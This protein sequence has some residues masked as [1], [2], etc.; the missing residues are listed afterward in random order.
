[1]SKMNKIDPSYI[2]NIR[3]G[4]KIENIEA[5]NIEALPEGLVGLYDKELF[6]PSLKWK[7]R[8]ETLQFFLVFA[9]A[10]KEI[11]VDFVSTILG[12]EWCKVLPN[13]NETSEEKRLKKVNEFIQLHSK[14]FT[15]AGEGKYR[16][17]HERFRLYILQ[18]VSESDLTQFNQKFISLCESELKKNTE[19]DIPE[20][21]YY[22]LEFLSTHYFISAMQGEKLCLNKKDAA[23]LKNLAYDQA[24]WERQVKASKGF[25]W[26]KKMLNEIMSWASKFD[27]EEVIECALNKVDL[28]HQEQNDAPR[29]VQL[30]A[31]G[32]IE[33]ALERIEKFGGEDKEGLQ[34]K[35]ILYMLCLMEL[36]LLDSKDKEHSKSSI[37]KILKHFDDKLPIE[38][39]VLNWNDFF[40]SYL[41]FLMAKEWAKSNLDFLIIYKRSLNWNYTWLNL[42]GPYSDLDFEILQKIAYIIHDKED[43]NN[44]CVA[45]YLQMY[46]QNKS[47]FLDLLLNNKEFDLM[48]D[49]YLELLKELDNEKSTFVYNLCCNALLEIQNNDLKNVKA[50][51]LSQ[52]LLDFDLFDESINVALI[53]KGKIR[54]K[55]LLN[56]AIKGIELDQTELAI[57]CSEKMKDEETKPAN[58]LEISKKLFL[59]N[60]GS[61]Y[62]ILNQSLIA[63]NRLTKAERKKQL[64]EIVLEMLKHNLTEAL[65]I[66]ESL[67]IKQD[68]IPEKVFGEIAV[69]YAEIGEFEK[70]FEFLKYVKYKREYI[71][72]VAVECANHNLFENAIDLFKSSEWEGDLS[73]KIK[74]L[75]EIFNIYW[76][77]G[78]KNESQKVKILAEGLINKT[79]DILEKNDLYKDLLLA[80]NNQHEFKSA[81][82]IAKKIKKSSIKVEVFLEIARELWIQNNHQ[83]SKILIDEA[84]SEFVLIDIGNSSKDKFLKLIIDEMINQNRENDII[85]IINNNLISSSSLTITH[86]VKK[87]LEVNDLKRA[88]DIIK[89][90]NQKEAILVNLE[91]SEYLFECGKYAESLKVLSDIQNSKEFNQH[92]NYNLK[93]SVSKILRKHGQIQIS[94][95]LLREALKFELKIKNSRPNSVFKP[96]YDI[97][98][99]F[100][101]QGL[102][103]E[104]IEIVNQIAI[105]NKSNKQCNTEK[106]YD[107]IIHSCLERSEFERALMLLIKINSNE[108]S[109]KEKY[110][111]AILSKSIENDR[112]SF[113]KKVLL[114]VV[115]STRIN[116]QTEKDE[117]L[118]TISKKF[119]DLTKID[120]SIK[121]V[122]EIKN[123]GLKKDLINELFIESDDEQAFTLEKLIKRFGSSNSML[124]MANLY[125]KNNNFENAISILNYVSNEESKLPIYYAIFSNI[126]QLNSIIESEVEIKKCL[127]KIHHRNYSLKCKN[128][129]F[130]S[131]ELYKIGQKNSSMNYLNEAIEL[132]SKINNDEFNNSK[133]QILISTE[134]FNQNE[135]DSSQKLLSAI[136]ESINL[137]ELPDD[138]IEICSAIY[139]ERL[140]QGEN[141]KVVIE[142]INKISDKD[143]QNSIFKNISRIL[144]LEEKWK[145]AFE[146]TI[147]L[148]WKWD[149]IQL[150]FSEMIKR[151]NF[152]LTLDLANSIDN[153]YDRCL[154]YISISKEIFK[155]EQKEK[156][157]DLLKEAIVLIEKSKDIK[158]DKDKNS[159]I[160]ELSEALAHVELFEL[161]LELLDNSDIYYQYLT[162]NIYI[163]WVKFNSD[164]QNTMILIEKHLK[165]L[166]DEDRKKYIKEICLY[167]VEID[168]IDFVNDILNKLISELDFAEDLL[169]V[170]S[171]ELAKKNNSLSIDLALKII[172]NDLLV[173]TLEKLSDSFIDNENFSLCEYVTTKIPSKSISTK[174]LKNLGEKLFETEGYFKAMENLTEFTNPESIIFIRKGIVEAISMDTIS[175]DIVKDVLRN[176]KIEE[177]YKEKIIKYSAINQLFFSN[178]PKEKLDRYNRTLNLQWAIDIKN[179]LPN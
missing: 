150:L 175:K 58:L 124:K 71:P 159:L 27:E 59:K 51:R 65:N 169:S 6:P 20:K 165:S 40:P 83:D 99:E 95:S 68:K 164:S 160:R 162:K 112:F 96:L 9:L 132:V 157:Q 15:S 54:D 166:Y 29:I 11:S 86:I 115:S 87:I 109:L 70:A 41:M 146:L 178:L 45:I 19:K 92:Y 100:V 18:K 173:K 129:V 120:Y 167:F 117:K 170:I 144:I 128:L 35:F 106:L 97:A 85:N 37:E 44:T 36:T 121:I 148:E 69:R 151:T 67:D 102:F 72:K 114:E 123:K 168:E 32:D 47:E 76:E 172:N 179:Q 5:N 80:L 141:L 39:S 55:L 153:S 113:N 156:A 105:E 17:Y 42:K 66:L 143:F 63:S 137:I 139:F 3:D 56:I 84:I 34:R 147:L 140:R 133:I 134:L 30:V 90:I 174:I 98:Q 177:V 125:L 22:A 111:N 46:I 122:N 50:S 25:E 13:E 21:E 82:E 127:D 14:R 119:K 118:Y 94:N 78:R 57:K 110:T 101:N 81:I 103:E 73:S 116:S 138:K 75:I 48:L 126:I 136:L 10:Q 61:S 107:L 89:N 158:L 93:L 33:T 8:K 88:Y 53:A 145:D 43:R 176:R 2:R 108:I 1:M 64:V 23:L 149:E 131:K 171:I 26:S 12:D 7:E 142:R 24:Y 49:L 130:I 62:L 91:I 77:S 16:L 154:A 104:V 135:I 163:K 79:D 31:D 161:A 60:Q 38:H 4:L 74:A 155:L 28:Y 52:I 152:N